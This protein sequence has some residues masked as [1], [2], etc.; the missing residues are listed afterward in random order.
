MIEIYRLPFWPAVRVVYR[1]GRASLQ[2]MVDRALDVRTTL[3]RNELSIS[4]D[5]PP[6][7]DH[8]PV[9]WIRLVHIFRHLAP[10][11]SDVLYDVGS[12][13]GRA[14][15]VAGQFPF[16]KIVGVE[17]SPE[18]HAQAEANLA[19][20]R[21]KPKAPV[22]LVHGNALEQSIPVGTSV[23]YFYNSFS[24]PVFDRFVD[25]LL[26][27]LDQNPRPLRFVYTNPIEHPKLEADE[28][29][30]LVHRFRGWRPTENWSR[31]LST[32]FYE[33]LPSDAAAR[34]VTRGERDAGERA[35]Q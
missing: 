35:A 27:D 4:R 23:V 30:R 25:H 2:L 1:F 3:L 14:L 7:F 20:C 8:G 11:Q 32:H 12:G 9:G 34:A 5:R 19:S 31:M 21:L 17:I 18:M 24:G 13:N 16:G 26:D 10:N 15:I 28:R 29:F 6:D 22:E 33:I